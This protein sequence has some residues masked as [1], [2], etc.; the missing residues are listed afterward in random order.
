MARVIVALDFD[1]TLT[2]NDTI[3]RIVSFIK[4]KHPKHA[5]FGPIDKSYYDALSHHQALWQP[6]LHQS[7][8]TKQLIAQYLGSF[9]DL[10][11]KSLARTNQSGILAGVT[12]QELWE[13]GRSVAFQKD[14]AK[15]I[16]ELVDNGS[17]RVCVVSVNWTK[18]YIKGALQA[19]G[20]VE[21]Q[22]VDVYC[23]D[24]EFDEDT[25][26][27]TGVVQPRMVVAQ[28]KVDA[29][30]RICEHEGAECRV[31]YVG[32]STTD[33]LAL[34]DADVGLLV[35]DNTAVLEWCDRLGV[36]LGKPRAVDGCTKTLHCLE[37][38]ADLGL[39]V[40]R[41]DDKVGGWQ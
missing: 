26:L 34:L 32:D 37:H 33:F 41:L 3:S 31:V 18:D 12:R 17:Y 20:V 35:G 10:E 30:A 13:A 27:S 40:R 1:K 14:A 9:R 8:L 29:I 6:Q 4:A 24:F 19:N 25:G 21:W 23:N 7:P 36:P 5:D 38:W 22:S 16:N 2:Q 28:D 15:A 39:L 11:E